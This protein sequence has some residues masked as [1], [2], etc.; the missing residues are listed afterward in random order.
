MRQRQ[1]HRITRCPT[2]STVRDCCCSAWLSEVHAPPREEQHSQ[3]QQRL[4]H[5]CS[6]SKQSAAGKTET[7]P[8]RPVE[9]PVLL[10]MP[11]IPWLGRFADSWSHLQPWA[12]SRSA[13][14]L[15]FPGLAG[16]RL[17][18]QVV[19][20]TPTVCRTLFA[21]NWS[22]IKDHASRS[23]ALDCQSRPAISTIWRS[24]SSIGLNRWARCSPPQETG[25]DCWV[26]HHFIPRQVNMEAVAASPRATWPIAARSGQVRT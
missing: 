18:S 14:D 15:R 23:R 25:I 7:E 26:C 16:R 19:P 9:S 21:T 11:S 2:S 24:V 10:T 4:H 12:K 22:S 13:R 1:G 17:P 20:P 3:L 5:V 6:G 8:L